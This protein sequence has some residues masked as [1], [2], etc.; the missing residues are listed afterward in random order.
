MNILQDIINSL[1]FYGKAD[2]IDENGNLIIIKCSVSGTGE[3]EYLTNSNHMFE[4]VKEPQI[5]SL[6]YSNFIIEQILYMLKKEPFSLKVLSLPLGFLGQTSREERKAA[7]NFF[8]ANV[9]TI[10]EQLINK[11]ISDLSLIPSIV[12]EISSKSALFLKGNSPD[13]FSSETINGMIKDDFLVLQEKLEKKDDEDV[14][15]MKDS[16][17]LIDL[18]KCVY[19]KGNSRIDIEGR[20]SIVISSSENG[21]LD[22][23]LQRDKLKFIK[24]EDEVS[25]KSFYGVIMELFLKHSLIEQTPHYFL[26]TDTRFSKGA[27]HKSESANL[28]TIKLLTFLNEFTKKSNNL[29]KYGAISGT[30]FIN[31]TIDWVKNVEIS[32][33]SDI[34][35]DIEILLKAVKSA[36]NKLLQAAKGC[37]KE[38]IKH[39]LNSKNTNFIKPN[40]REVAFEAV[41]KKPKKM[42][43]SLLDKAGIT[44]EFIDEREFKVNPAVGRTREIRKLGSI[45]LTPSYSVMLIGEPGVGKTAI[46]EGLSYAI[47]NDLVSD[48]LKN[49]RI[50]KI[51]I[52]SIISDTRYVGTLEQKMEALI[53]FFKT[54]TDAILYI[55]EIHTIIGAGASSKDNNDVSN[56]LKPHI[57]NGS[58]KMIGATTISEYDK[59]LSSDSAFARR[60]KQI[61]VEEPKIEILRSILSSDIEKFE[62]ITG[63][64][65]SSSESLRDKMIEFIIDITD[66]KYRTYN[67]Q[68][69]NPALSLSIIEEAFGYADYD[70][71]SEVGI[72]YL[73]EAVENCEN[74]YSSVK[75]KVESLDK[76][77]ESKTKCKII[78]FNSKEG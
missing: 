11:D 77:T 47:R 15:N 34:N 28:L 25:I 53:K 1:Y 22:Y 73:K 62:E 51:N 74:I 32:Y 23:Y 41:E 66:K 43:T 71:E 75:S 42:D 29:C 57:E 7:I 19:E 5:I 72:K 48:R 2:I 4:M 70:G 38:D 24:M 37:I 12:R 78:K 56:M 64:K 17:I 60:F 8:Y 46:V 55:D 13:N 39:D 6:M 58:I 40:F 54:N 9:D 18:V 67:E 50:I 30:D 49:K 10:I 68:R 35:F 36:S 76:L 45:L 59:Y 69:Y 21:G 31:Y 20:G 16:N 14:I 63:I 33:F 3:L 52:S 61:L 65:F 27:L 44:Y 26:S